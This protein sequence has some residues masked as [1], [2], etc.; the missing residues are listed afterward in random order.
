MQ[1]HLSRIRNE[2]VGWP[3]SAYHHKKSIHARV[4]SLKTVYVYGFPRENPCMNNFY[5]KPGSVWD[6]FMGRNRVQE[7]GPLAFAKECFTDATLLR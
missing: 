2:E 1:P 4:S 7:H 3:R 5:R 6:I